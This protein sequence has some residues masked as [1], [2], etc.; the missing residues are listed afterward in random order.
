MQRRALYLVF[1]AG[2]A[3]PYLI[4]ADNTAPLGTYTPSQ[5]QHWAFV[6]R[7]RPQAPQFSL[8]ADRNWVKN[9]VDAFILARLKKEGLRPARPADRATLI[10]RVY[11]DLIGLPPAPGEV[12][13]F[14]ADKSPDSYPKLV[15]RLLASPQYGERWGRH[16]LDVVRFAETDGFEYDT[17][18]RDAW[19]YRDYVINAFNNDKPYDRF[20]LEQLAGDEIGPNQDETLIAAGFNR[21]GPLRKNAGNQEVASSRNEVLTEMTNVVGSS[22]LGVTLGCARCHD[23]MFDPIKQSDYYRMQAYFAATHEKDVTKATAEE[24]AAWKAKAEPVEQEIKRLREAMKYSKDEERQA[25]QK[26][27]EETQERMPAPLPALFSVSNDAGKQSPIHILARGEYQKKGDRVGMRPLGVL[28]PEEMPE[29]P[30]S[31]SDPRTSLAKWIVDPDN[32]LT[33]RVL[34]NRIWHYHFGRGIVATPNDFGRRGA[35]PSHPELLDYLANEFVSSGFRLK[36]MHRLIL[37]SNTYRQSSERADAEAKKKDPE[38]ILLWKFNRRRLEAE[39]IRD[40]MLSV[41]GTLN[42]K[43]GGPSV[44][45]P[46]DKELVNA[47]YKPSQWAVTADPQEHSRRSIYLIVKRNLRLPFMEAFDAPDAL[48]S[49]AR[50]ESSTH[51]PQALE[52][53]NGTFANSQAEAL[54]ARL[55]GEA[56]TDRARLVDLAY[57]LVS[58]R[59]PNAKETRLALD[60]LRTQSMREFTLAMFNL[61]AFLYVN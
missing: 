35:R 11:F 52:L 59:P 37:L 17:H 38:N 33:A 5:R 36:P 58:G 22:L 21:L 20:I 46:I 57:R 45:V 32:P 19:R 10:R 50:R 51:A 13:R 18:R 25:L 48:V 29:Q 40:A 41:A 42:L 6:K 28:V 47:L 8:A 30:P 16:W 44:I 53:L 7:S 56:W 60:F 1:I 49:C 23:H 61:N 27:L 14:I 24:Q 3:L 31:A 9:P 39:E 54:A 12:A 55:Q 4:G 15:E 34:V 26:K 43:M 2:T